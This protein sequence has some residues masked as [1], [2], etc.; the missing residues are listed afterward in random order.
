VPILWGMLRKRA[1]LRSLDV[2]LPARNRALDY[3]A[4]RRHTL[5]DDLRYQLTEV[6]NGYI[7]RCDEDA[8]RAGIEWMRERYRDNGETPRF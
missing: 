8:A 6:V 3:L 4:N 2:P 1:R 7:G 5:S